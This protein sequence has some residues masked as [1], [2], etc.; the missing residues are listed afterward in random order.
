[1]P[2]ASQP[3]NTDAAKKAKKEAPK[4][5]PTA[6]SDEGAGTGAGAGAGAGAPAP[7]GPPV[8]TGNPDTDLVLHY[9]RAQNRPYS[10]QQISENLHGRVKKSAVETIMMELE[11]GEH[12]STKT[13]GK[14]R[15][16]WIV[17]DPAA[18]SFEAVMAAHGSMKAAVEEGA[19][20]AARRRALEAQVRTLEGA[21]KLEKVV[22]ELGE[23]RGKKAALSA[24]VAA[25][26]A[27][28]ATGAVCN[29]E[30]KAAAL[31]TLDRYRRAWVDR[32]G[33]ALEL[34]DALCEGSDDPAM[35][36]A[37]MGERMGMA[38]DEGGTSLKDISTQALAAKLGVPQSV[39]VPPMLK[40]GTKQL[41]LPAGAGGAAGATKK[42]K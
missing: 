2:A 17:Q 38:M 22:A 19:K 26:V 14:L 32:K 41:L 12:V 40:P 3:A 37:K 23:L 13:F 6:A 7:S 31:R 25:T 35:T 9:L 39:L 30:T 20:V 18:G 15:L 24:R 27:A 36:P 34:L 28:R 5:A 33:R 16:A 10:A 42:K 21:P 29:A 4:A 11:A 8:V 1:M